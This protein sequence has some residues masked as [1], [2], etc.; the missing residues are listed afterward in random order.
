MGKHI[1]GRLYVDHSSCSSAEGKRLSVGKGNNRTDNKE[2]CYVVFPILSFG[3]GRM[4]LHCL[5]SGI[6]F[7]VLITE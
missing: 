7:S 6:D 5:L 2:P 3:L 1:Q 4:S